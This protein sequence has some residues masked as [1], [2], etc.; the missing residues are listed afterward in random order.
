MNRNLC[1]ELENG[2]PDVIKALVEIC[3]ERYKV[4]YASSDANAITQ[5]K[6]EQPITP[7]EAVMRTEGTSFPVSDL[8]EHLESILVN[9]EKHYAHH[10]VGDLVYNTAGEVEWRLNTNAKPLYTYDVVGDRRGALEIFEM[11]KK[12]AEGV[13][14]WGRYIA[15]I[16]PIDA[17]EGPSLFSILFMDTFTDR[18]VA[19]YTGRPRRARDAYEIALRSLRF[20]NAEA[21]YEANLKGLFS[22]FDER[23]ALRH[24]ADTPQIL[25][26]MEFIKATNLY[27][28][29]AK[30]TH[31]NMAINK[32]GRQRWADWMLTPTD[33][34]TEEAPKL[35][36]QT[37]RGTALIEEC[38][39][40]NHDGNFDRVSAGIMLF[41]LREDRYKRIRSMKANQH[42]KEVSLAQDKFFEKNYNP[43]KNNPARNVNVF[44][45]EKDSK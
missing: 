43:T 13:I 16:D 3:L 4:K 29:R 18:I 15:G 5:K 36:L 41:I 11:P 40:W 6:A 7:Q 45:V 35:K 38:I 42:A 31:N 9:R 39:K 22:Y 26:D 34:S 32:F 20:Y 23:N 28:N 19:E 8:K 12:N 30:G 44:E 2:E 1:Y 25:R 21:N 33:D 17:D 10:Y 14:P 27:G 37:L 24:L